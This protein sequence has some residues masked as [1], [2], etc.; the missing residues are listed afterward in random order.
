MSGRYGR[1]KQRAD[2]ATED[3]FAFNRQFLFLLEDFYR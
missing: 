3:R 2:D 1:A